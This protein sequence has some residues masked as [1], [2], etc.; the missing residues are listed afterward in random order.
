MVSA[1]DNLTSYKDLT[2]VNYIISLDNNNVQG[3]LTIVI[4][5]A[6]S[7]GWFLNN[8]VICSAA[9]FFLFHE[10][11]HINFQYYFDF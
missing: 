4:C 7:A 10:L 11:T 1:L 5:S 2:P 9:V 6:D 8:H 3:P